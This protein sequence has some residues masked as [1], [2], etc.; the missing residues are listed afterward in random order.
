MREDSGSLDVDELLRQLAALTK[1]RGLD[2]RTADRVSAA[3]GT[4]DQAVRAARTSSA[5][6][7]RQQAVDALSELGVPA[8]P[9]LIAEFHR[10]RFDS[11]LAPRALAS[12]RRDELRAFRAKSSTRSVWVVPALTT[13][14]LPARGYLALS[15]WP[16][17]LR[18]HGTRSGRVD[19][20]RVLLVLLDTLAGLSAAGSDRLRAARELRRIRL[21]DLLV[22]LGVG[23]P[24]IGPTVDQESA[25]EAIQAEL[26]ELAA[27]DRAERD[28]AALTLSTVD[29]EQRLFGRSIKA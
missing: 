18:I 11:E 2:Q 15:S 27:K 24:G 29:E 21:T 6:P 10:A 25:R 26:D 3:L 23:V 13:H 28:A 7:A 9:A 12:I 1:T 17:W 4:A 19:T 22:R 20:L 16:A 14:L 5:A 8:N